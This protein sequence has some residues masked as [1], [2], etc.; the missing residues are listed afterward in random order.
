MRKVYL[1]ALSALAIAGIAMAGC[2]DKDPGPSK[3]TEQQSDRLADIQKKTGGDWS[4]L[5]TEDHDYLVK[6]LAHGSESTAKML[7]GPPVAT[8]GGP[9]KK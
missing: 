4:K 2:G 1:F 6:D 3:E 8:P 5:T 7:L 9:P